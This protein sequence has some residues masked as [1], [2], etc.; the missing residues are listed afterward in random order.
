MVNALHGEAA[1]IG[2][3][4]SRFGRMPEESVLSLAGEALTG[5]LDD[6]GLEKEAIDGLIVHNGSPRG[7]DYDT[8][9][10]IFGLRPRFC[11]QS[12]AHG[13]FTATNITHAVLAV[14]NG[15]AD[16]VAC[17]MAFKNSDIGRLGEAN[18][19]M[20]YEMFREAGGPHSEE[21]FIGMT[22]GIAGAAMGFDAYCR[23]YNVDRELLGIIPVTFRR[24]A[25]LNPSAMSKGTITL[26]DYRNGRPIIDPLR[27]FDCSLVSDGA[28]CVIISRKSLVVPEQRP[29]WIIGAQGIQAGRDSFIFAPSGLG[30]MQ[31][32]TRRRT[33]SEARAQTIYKMSDTQPESLDVLGLFDSFSPAPVY[34]LEEFGFCEAGEALHW[35]R[36]GTIGLGGKFPTNTAGGQLSEAQLNGWGQIRELVAQL[37]GEAGQRQ[38]PGARRGM[39]AMTGGDSLIF[40]RG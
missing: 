1:V 38:V 31:Q 14:T 27:L 37:R 36:D 34:L 18:N 15:L 29:V 25:M 19:P 32:D 3:G 4:A 33:L 10:Q 13:R 5:A 12:W 23:R 24:H 17:L 2:V 39:W 21:G 28:I 26:E 35:I 8:I 9:A 22:S 20:Y 40:E 11:A 30:V 6:A 7:A 16:R